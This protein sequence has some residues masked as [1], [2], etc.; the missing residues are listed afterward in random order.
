LSK[1]FVAVSVVTCVVLS[2]TCATAALPAAPTPGSAALISGTAT[3]ASSSAAAQPGT[4]IVAG[5][6]GSAIRS[7][8]TALAAGT[9]TP[10]Q[11][12][13]TA[14]SEAA[15]NGVNDYLSVLD[16][17]SGAVLAQ[18]SSG[19]QVAS[20]SIMKLMLAAYY[21]VLVGGYQ[22]QSAGVL[23]DL[24]Y[25][26]RYSDDSTANAYFSSAAIPTIAA[27][28]GMRSTINA[29]D[30][31]GHW[32]AARI[33]AADMTTFLY[34]AG[35]DA[36]VGPWLLPVMAA[37]APSGSDGFNQAF[38]MNSLSG[39]HGSKQ[40][41]GNDQFWSSASNVI[42]S[43]GYT[44]R[45]YVAIL[46]NSYTYA[47]PARATA[48]FA[49]RTI[50]ASRRVAATPPPPPAPP[51][52]GDFIRLTGTT[53]VY[54]LVGGAPVY[55]SSWAPFGG[56]KPVKVLTATQWRTLRAVPADGTFITASGRGEVYRIAGGAPIYLH[57]WSAVGG[58]HPSVVVDAAAVA[59]A[60]HSGDW[61]HLRATPAD[62]TYLTA[63]GSGQVFR[64]VGGAPVYVASW[65]HFGGSR[66][67]TLVDA[68][69]VSM[70]GHPGIWSHLRRIVPD[71]T[72]IRSTTGGEVYRIA[73]GAPVYV[74]TWSA[75]GRQYSSQLVDA[76]AIALAG[77]PGQWSHLAAVPRDG[78]Y[79][80]AN[81]T[82][83]IF[84]MA[85]GAPLYVAALAPLDGVKV[86]VKV[87]VQ[88]INHGGQ[89]GHWAHLR[90]YP[91]DGTFL[92]C[93]PAGRVYRVSGGHASY[94]RS[95]AP[96]GGTRPSV[97]INQITVDR[98]GSGGVFN[99]LRR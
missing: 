6:E 75:F 70:A 42:N 81:G 3:A 45:Y 94:V 18:S 79:L 59:N 84:R 16:R 48:S 4:P 26:I 71:G 60:G 1:R 73:G 96:Y 41:W 19:T 98:A 22:H 35:R 8:L 31:V 82:T 86:P 47:D 32:G 65:A 88:A 62:G 53:A 25:M 38:G 97:R 24:S 11:A 14:H 83:A 56:S 76:T 43:V 77:R 80:S 90:F 36:Q 39:T 78:T 50:Q 49:A 17:S 54:R 29:T 20:E 52:S 55:V 93:M 10:A 5:V 66:P 72:F 12:V 85:G 9:L 58:Q 27:R 23:A 89:A 33:T 37:V 57:A 2:I 21:L 95:W 30:R 99:H 34:R 40:G 61:S 28:Y 15:A 7:V 44:D 63:S 91:A 46:Q 74:S 68:A 13:A 92:T 67:S 69:A 87:D 64:T 51:K